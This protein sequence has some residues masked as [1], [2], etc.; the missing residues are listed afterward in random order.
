MFDTLLRMPAAQRHLI[1]PMAVSCMR[2]QRKLR[3]QQEI[4]CCISESA[5]SLATGGNLPW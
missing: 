5:E 2:Q 1:L 4:C 3:I